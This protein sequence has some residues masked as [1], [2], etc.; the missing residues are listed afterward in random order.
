MSDPDR[1]AELISSLKRQRDELA[2]QIH[3]GKQEAK[4]E[5]EK[6]T[7]KL[8]ELTKDYE[9]LTDAVEETSANVV[10]ALKLVAGE[11]QQGFERIRKAL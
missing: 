1:L 7:A 2:L 10:A 3:L 5:W 6:V 9:P 8:D 11:I 4:D